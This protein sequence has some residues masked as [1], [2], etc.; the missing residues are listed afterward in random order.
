[1]N[2]FIFSM[3]FKRVAIVIVISLAA[4]AHAFQLSLWYA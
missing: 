2:D 3:L 4:A 1:M